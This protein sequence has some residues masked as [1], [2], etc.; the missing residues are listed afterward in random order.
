MNKTLTQTLTKVVVESVVASRGRKSTGVKI[1]TLVR[2][3]PII[4]VKPF[5]K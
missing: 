3:I 5:S 2:D 1:A 4:T